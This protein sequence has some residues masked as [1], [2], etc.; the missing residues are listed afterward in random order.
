MFDVSVSTLAA[1]G[2]IPDTTGAGCNH[3]GHKELPPELQVPLWPA[4]NVENAP[5]DKAADQPAAIAGRQGKVAGQGSVRSC[6]AADKAVGCGLGD[7]RSADMEVTSSTIL[8]R[9]VTCRE[10]A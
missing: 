6:S 4:E 5:Q 1:P 3:A 9:T 7:H 8:D 2:T 10:D